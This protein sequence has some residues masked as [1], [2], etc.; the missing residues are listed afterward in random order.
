MYVLTSSQSLLSMT[1]GQSVTQIQQQ[2]F[3][4]VKF[5]RL[6]LWRIVSRHCGPRCLKLAIRHR[7]STCCRC[8]WVWYIISIAQCTMYLQF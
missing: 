5:I 1:S 2:I 6:N 7:N 8:V 3:T 4:I